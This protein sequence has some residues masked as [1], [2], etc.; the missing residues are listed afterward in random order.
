MEARNL[1]RGLSKGFKMTE[2]IEHD[3]HFV[4]D[5]NWSAARKTSAS[6]LRTKVFRIAVPCLIV[7]SVALCVLEADWRARGKQEETWMKVVQVFLE[8]CFAFEI[9]LRIYA[10]RLRFFSSAVNIVDL[11][12]VSLDVLMTC[13]EYALRDQ[14]IPQASILR[15]VRIIRAARVSRILVH[16]R[17]LHLLV[18]GF[19]SGMRTICYGVILILLF[20]L[21]WSIIAVEVLRPVNN[22]LASEGVYGDCSYCVGA[23]DSIPQ[24]MVTFFTIAV[25]GDS[26]GVI[27]LPMVDRQP[28]SSLIFLGVLATIQLGMMNLILAVI[29]ERAHE[30][31]EEDRYLQ[32]LNKEEQYQE[33]CAK[34]LGV[35]QEL[36]TDNSGHVSK[37]ELV[38]G[39]YD[40]LEFASLL[41]LMDICVDELEAVF[42]I[43]DVDKSGTVSYK[44]FV[45]QLHRLRTGDSHTILML[46]KHDVMC[47]HDRLKGHAKVMQTDAE[48]TRQV[49]QQNLSSAVASLRDDLSIAMGSFSGQ[50]P[51]EPHMRTWGELLDSKLGHGRPRPGSCEIAGSTSLP[52]SLITVGAS[53]VGPSQLGPAVPDVRLQSVVL[54]IQAELQRLQQQLELDYSQAV[55]R[56]VAGVG[57]PQPTG[58]LSIFP[59]FPAGPRGPPREYMPLQPSSFPPEKK[60]VQNDVVTGSRPF[61]CCDGQQSRIVQKT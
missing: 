34:L 49:L 58:A 52:E 36:D 45:D 12:V 29:V 47:V 4:I 17:E 5:P 8:V 44:E 50:L 56:A 18:H 9:A 61:G 33:S 41:K 59:S 25:A 22:E 15:L 48:E 27:V 39:A 6:L 60:S 32:H 35:C 57:M 19:I 31:R 13:M 53:S 14:G 7:L 43:L 30:S 23:F 55:G 20:L 51:T 10:Q 26:W 3:H 28:W 21:I 38:K 37:A 46:I 2:V 40:S 24:S 16:F 54:K 1:S 42:E 11:T